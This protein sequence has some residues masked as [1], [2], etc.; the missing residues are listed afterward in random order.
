MRGL[1]VAHRLVSIVFYGMTAAA[2]VQFALRLIVV[3]RNLTQTLLTGA[4][5][6]TSA[7]AFCFLVM[8]VL[9][10]FGKTQTD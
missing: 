1:E 5:Y 6:C 3:D 7:A 10:L 4:I 2:G 9:G 8:L